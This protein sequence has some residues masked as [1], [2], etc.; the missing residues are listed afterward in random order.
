YVF[1]MERDGRVRW[2]YRAGAA[3]GNNAI[4]MDDRRVYLI[5]RTEPEKVARAKRRG[6][7]I[8]A[9]ARLVAID[10]FSGKVLWHTS[11]GIAGRS[12]LWLASG[13]LLA[14]G[15]GGMSGYEAAG[16]R[17]LYN[18]PVSMR[19]FPVIVGDTIYG[20]P[21][22][23]DLRTGEPKQRLHPLA[24]SAST[25][26]FS[27]SYGCGAVSGAPN[28]LLFRS[29]TLGIYD[30][31]GDSGVH[32]FGGV[33]PGCHVNA[34]AANG[35]VLMP[36]GDAGCT[37]SYCYQ[38]TVVLEP[39]Y[40]HEEWAIFYERLPNTSVRQLALN[41]GAPGDRRDSDGRLWLAA[42]RPKTANRRR[43]I[44]V[45][46]RF[47]TRGRFGPYRFNAEHIDVA[48]TD[49]PWLYT[50][51]LKGALRAELDLNILERGITAWPADTAPAI[52]GEAR[53]A[54]WD[55]YKAVPV[56]GENASVTVRYDDRCLYV[57][58]KRKP[59]VDP[60]GRLMPWKSSVQETDGPV[61][62]DHSFELYFSNIPA[63]RNA[64]SRS[65]LHLGVS[66]SGTRY[67]A[68]WKYVTPDLPVCNIPPVDA[69]ID[70]DSADWAGKGLAVTSLPGPQGK[71]RSPQDFD[72][73]FKIGWNARGIVI[74]AQVKDNV[75]RP[76]AN[77]EAL[78]RGD[79]VEVFVTPKRGS[80]EYY[81]LLVAPSADPKS[82]KVKRRFYDHRKRSNAA[83]LAA[84]L[85]GMRTPDGY[86]IEI[87]LPWQNLG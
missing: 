23:Y 34:I 25:W 6:Q 45:P 18:R 82:P 75:V 50:S 35:L 11:E 76:A 40:R 17:L 54:C 46:F 33:R 62:K 47:D 43:D 31:A 19:R 73:C 64:G 68:L 72:P 13:V 87:L 28:L 51:G 38:T 27:R 1:I 14:T 30:L 78:R 83:K 59:L 5:E 39:G 7:R 71:L 2:T 77:E 44:A 69:T 61:W 22:A 26:Q 21:L 3:V 81:R 9:R 42:P 55:D 12:E 86:V 53:D 36:P 63:D 57:L 49:R 67:D 20:E 4:T 65:Y 60:A 8:R 74:L 84:E 56:T 29:S 41:L 32:N 37:C 24:G 58:H 10:A 16:G 48:G 85:A 70:G 15:G 79:S 52:D 80:S 66:A